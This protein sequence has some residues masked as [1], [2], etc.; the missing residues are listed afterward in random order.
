VQATVAAWSRIDGCRRSTTAPPSAPL[1]L[2]LYES[3]RA[4]TAVGLIAIAGGTHLWPGSADADGTPD[5]A[6]S[7]T[8][9]I[10]GFLAGHPRR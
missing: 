2:D 1:T 10:W 8:A 4:G 6:L 3:C 9:V 5:A 7:A